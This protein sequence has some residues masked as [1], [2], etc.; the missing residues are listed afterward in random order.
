MES[1][2]L[3]RLTA[4]VV[5]ALI[6]ARAPLLFGVRL[7][8]SVCFA[9][10]L[11]FWL[12]LDNPSW[13]GAT[14][15]IVCQPQLGAS[16][17]KGWFRMIGTVVGAVAIVLLTALFVQD[18]VAYL[19]ALALWCAVCA[20]GA[21]VLQNFASYAA[22]LAGY[23][24]AVIAADTLGATGG[25]SPDVFL[26]AV[27]RASEICIGIAC[28]GVVLAGTDL[29][30]AQRR[31]AVS[32]ADLATDI[33]TRFIRMLSLAEAQLP[34]T[35]AERRELVRR[36][37][38]LDPAIDETL[39][40]SSHIR[41]HAAT[42]QAAVYGLLGALNA[43][44]AVATHLS[45]LPQGMDRLGAEIVLRAIPPELRSGSPARW[46][47]D[48][49][50][51]RRVCENGLRALIALPASTPSLR[52]LAD[53]T[54]KLLAGLSRALDGLALLVDAPRRTVPRG[55]AFRTGVPDW[56]PALV[57]AARAFVA[58]AAVELFWVATAWPNGGA[59]IVFAAILLLLLAPRGDLAYRAGIALALGAA[60]AIAC[61]A[62]VKFALLPALASF[63]AFCFALGLVLVPV[64]FVMAQSRNPVAVTVI[65]AIAIFF[66]PLL[67]PT[68]L[69]S[70]DTAAFYNSVLSVVAGFAAALMAFR[71]LP[72]LSPALRA[73]R[74][75]ARSLRDLRRLVATTVPAR[76]EDW[77]GR[78]T[79]RLAAM[80]NEA[81]P[82]QRAQL[83]AVLSVG[84]EII[85]L[86]HMAPR[87]G[88][89][90]ELDA[91]L[92]ALAQGNSALAL[93]QLHQL[94]SRL[95]ADTR[96]QATVT[97]RVRSR[98]RVMSEALAQHAAYFDAGAPA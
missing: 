73:R 41:F 79:G 35:Q 85:H 21:T 11:A 92:A 62:G 32:F 23:T 36:T 38:A 58:I 13:A 25:A 29:G 91:A 75:L 28:A 20:F 47:A 93:T 46:T 51:L 68:N 34:E 72:P 76:S 81:A 84:S 70:Y 45:R 17:R 30:G 27:D 98:I 80:P 90:A 42:L 66:L 82:P 44:R 49:V 57:A 37:I 64:G 3:P 94:D 97:L 71:L 19:A 67:S 74:L 12:Q 77:E 78:M 4:T 48:P 54:A 14:A 83:L 16:L 65:G 56:L 33:V 10:L 40:E 22:A 59:A 15:A 86:R 96:P 50:A 52:L 61:A 31:L 2:A 53:E 18:R 55:R 9:L 7:W 26:L 43:W 63:P 39:G 60:G 87:L 89:A 6:A 69:M 1:A 24:A 5:D 8:A 95:A 88:A